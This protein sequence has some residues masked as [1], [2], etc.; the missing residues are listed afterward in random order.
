MK[1]EMIECNPL[2]KLTF[3][4]ALK[5]VSYTELLETKQKY[6]LARQLFKSGTSIGANA[7]EAQNAESKADFVHKIKLA[8]KEADETQYWLLLCEKA[9]NYETPGT[10]LEQ[11]EEVQRLLNSILKTAKR[12]N[13]G[14]FLWGSI[15]FFITNLFLMNT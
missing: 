8:A 12:N 2:L 15:L 6:T 14:S 9:E 3:E 5:I 10:M 11:L 7:M 13:P 4:F 1:K